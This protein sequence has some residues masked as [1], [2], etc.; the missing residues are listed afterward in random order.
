MV[1]RGNRIGFGASSCEFASR[2]PNLSEAQESMPQRFVIAH[3]LIQV[4]S[5]I[6]LRFFPPLAI[7]HIR[8][9]CRPHVGCPIC[10]S[11]RAS[12]RLQWA[13]QPPPTCPVASKHKIKRLA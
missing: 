2:G 7:A 13:N 12:H 11:F 10:T 8:I 5:A 1:R 3:Y 6:P 4:W 9:C